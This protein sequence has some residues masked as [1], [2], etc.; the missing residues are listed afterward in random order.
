MIPDSLLVVGVPGWLMMQ[1]PKDRLWGALETIVSGCTVAWVAF[2]LARRRFKSERWH[3]RRGEAYGKFNKFLHEI[4]QATGPLATDE[5][6]VASNLLPLLS[7]EKHDEILKKARLAEE[8]L[9]EAF[10]EHRY[11]LSPKAARIIQAYIDTMGSDEM[12][13]VTMK[14]CYWDAVAVEARRNFGELLL[15][16]VGPDLGFRWRGRRIGRWI[17]GLW[18]SGVGLQ[19]E[20]FRRL[21]TWWQDQRL[22]FGPQLTQADV[23][24]PPRYPTFTTVEQMEKLGWPRVRIQRELRRQLAAEERLKRRK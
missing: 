8:Q 10:A 22:R 1:I 2:L 14:H 11:L 23:P 5:D 6:R 19:R 17:R 4:A 15:V 3:E 16:D 12:A 13:G 7:V 9:G 24:N 18:W 20:T 21:S